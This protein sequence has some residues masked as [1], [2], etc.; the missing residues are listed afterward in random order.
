[1]Q[2]RRL[3]TLRAIAALIVLVGH[4]SNRAHLWDALLG[5]RAPQLGVMLFF[6][7]SAFLMTI[8]YMDR[9]PT[10]DAIATY[11]WARAARV[12]PL[13]VVVVL[14]SHLLGKLPIAWLQA[15]VYAI[16]DW[17]AVASHLLFLFG[18]QVLWTI[19][20]EIHFYAIFALL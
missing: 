14:A 13:F 10:R 15:S 3:N 1:M 18:V 7:L 5:T 20:A 17:K 9:R 16:P 2:I 19:P 12:L 11:A 8:L 4:F 6:L